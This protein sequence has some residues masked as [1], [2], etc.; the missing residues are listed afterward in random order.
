MER[1]P[2]VSVIMPVYNGTAYLRQAIDSILAQTFTDF[3]F[4]ILNDGS[5]DDSASV[6]SS[7]TDA[8]IKYASHSN[9]GLA[10][11]LNTG[12]GMARGRYI[13]RQD[14]DDISY[15]ERLKT[16]V[17][18]MEEN[19]SIVLLGTWAR[20]FTDDGNEMGIHT[21]A[22]HPAVLRFDLLFDNPFVHSSVIFRKDD[23]KIIGNYNTDSSCYEDFDLWSRFA[24][25]GPVANLPQV[26]LEYRHHEKG[27]SKDP[28][29]YKSASA[30]KQSLRN[31]E[32]LLGKS[33]KVYNDLAALFHWHEDKLTGA[34]NAELNGALS[35]IAAKVTEFF[36]DDR[37]LVRKRLSEYKRVIGYRIN[38]MRR[39]GLK[40]DS[41]RLLMLRFESK[42]RRLQPHVTNT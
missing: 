24:K 28:S 33:G 22:T 16:Q 3:E 13:A 36:P 20:I 21:H 11:T 10:A 4:I 18:F 8:R 6:I 35:E 14:Q 38:K 31:I 1:S 34:S 30:F 17:A 2:L 41:L 19:S 9:R 32:A 39:K 27:L 12:I 7:Y 23:I 5:T 15:P 29:Y 40:K 26:L 37:P 42:I 25:H